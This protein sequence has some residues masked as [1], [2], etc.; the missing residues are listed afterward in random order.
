[1][2]LSKK[3]LW[4]LEHRFGIDPEVSSHL[5]P[6]LER[7]ADQPLSAEDGETL[8]RGMAQAMRSAQLR[9]GSSPELE[10]RAL[11][12]EF[13]SE[14]RKVDESVK[15]LSV[16][17]ERLQQRTAPPVRDPRILH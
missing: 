8:L 16:Y 5:A 11:L 1:M 12:G 10:V 14:L 6:V 2:T 7:I 17:L 3:W 13:L 4:E 15:V 9:E